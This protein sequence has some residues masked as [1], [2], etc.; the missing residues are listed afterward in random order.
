MSE[1]GQSRHVDRAPLTPDLPRL[2]DFLRIIRLV[3]NVPETVG[4]NSF[5][6]VA[7]EDRTAI[8]HKSQNCNPMIG[9][10]PIRVSLT[11]WDCPST[12]RNMRAAKKT[13]SKVNNQ[14]IVFL[15]T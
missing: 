15:G 14:A 11:E 2:A 12:R 10:A 5:R 13:V 1:M 4:Q 6:R 3:S 7:S 8:S 9:A